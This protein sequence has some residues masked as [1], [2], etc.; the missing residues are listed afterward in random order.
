MSIRI[1]LVDDFE[2]W[3]RAVCLMVQ[4]EAGLQIIAEAADGIAAV[5][6]AKELEPD[7]ILMDIGLPG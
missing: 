4:K 3:R 5:Q 2:P 7:L 1:L 6:N